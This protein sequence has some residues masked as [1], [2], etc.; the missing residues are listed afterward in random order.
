MGPR[1][2]RTAAELG[3]GWVPIFMTRETY[4]A[5]RAEV[6]RIRASVGRDARPFTTSLGPMLAVNDDP[7]AA[8]VDVASNLAWYLCCMGETYPALARA[9][10]F[11]NIRAGAPGDQLWPS[12]ATDAACDNRANTSV[13]GATRPFS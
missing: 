9:Q 10:G 12:P 11:G 5:R 2:V 6:D 7:G 4:L 3:D 8:R 13:V 1:N